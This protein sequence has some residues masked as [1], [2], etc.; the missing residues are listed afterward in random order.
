MLSIHCLTTRE[1]VELRTG[2]YLSCGFLSCSKWAEID[3]NYRLTIDQGTAVGESNDP[4]ASYDGMAYSNGSAFTTRD[5]DHDTYS[6]NCAKVYGGAWWYRDCFHANLN[7]K[8]V[9]HIPSGYYVPGCNRLAWSNG[10]YC[11]HY[12]KVQMKIRPKRCSSTAG[13]PSCS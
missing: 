1:D 10:N 6:D 7:G 4:M 13:K 5:R 3:T 12:T 9:P 8:Y 2:L 11:Q